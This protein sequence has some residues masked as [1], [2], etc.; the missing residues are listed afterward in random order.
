MVAFPESLIVS[1][2][3]SPQVIS[4]LVVLPT[5]VIVNVIVSP[6]DILTELDTNATLF[7]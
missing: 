5:G 7:T 4:N 1:L 6:D 3:P 2:L